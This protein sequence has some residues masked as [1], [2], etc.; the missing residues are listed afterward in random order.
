MSLIPGNVEVLAFAFQTDKDTPADAPVMA[1][2]LEDCSLDPGVQRITTPETDAAALAPDDVVVGAQPGGTFK[3]Y[4][5]P[6]EVDLFMYALLGKNDDA[7]TDPT[8]HT[9]ELD[10]TAPFSSPYLTIWDIWPGIGCV[11]YTGARIGQLALSSQEGGAVESEYT[12]QAL[13]ATFLDIGD[14]P[15][16]SGLF[17]DEQPFTW[18]ELAVSLAGTHG[19]IVSQYQLTVN[20]NINRFTGDNGLESLDIPNGLFAVTGSMTVAF[21]DDELWRASNTGTVDGT[22]LTTSIFEESID[23]DHVRGADLEAKF[24]LAEARITNFKTKIETD[25]KV[26]TASF[27]FKSKRSATLT[28]VF[29]S[30]VVN[31]Q[32]HADRS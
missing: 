1:I 23:I 32:A 27:D 31:A 24:S 8:T 10:D 28:D 6:D 9:A 20:R 3:C 15:D 30:L 25:G 22:D 14:A 29:Q 5:R 17:V 19:G 7:G 4:L 12:I 2:A 26:A 21:E 13:K 11:Q 18:A 16:L